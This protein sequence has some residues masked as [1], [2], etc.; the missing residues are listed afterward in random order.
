MTLT[1][2]TA[3]VDRA[4]RFSLGMLLLGMGAYIPYVDH[5]A[6]IAAPIVGLVLVAVAV[7]GFCPIFGAFGWGETTACTV[8]GA[9]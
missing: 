4:I 1:T 3:P 7:T 6:F 5:W 8:E 2:N 9:P